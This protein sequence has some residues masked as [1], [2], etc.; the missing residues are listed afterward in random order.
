MVKESSSDEAGE[1]GLIVVQEGEHQRRLERLLVLILNYR[2][3]LD[4][5]T[6]HTLVE[7]FSLFQKYG[8]RIRCTAVIQDRKID[9]KTS[10][11]AISRNGNIPLLLVLPDHLLESHRAICQQ[12]TNVYYCGWQQASGRAPKSLQVQIETAFSEQGIG[13]IFDEDSASLSHKEMQVCVERRLSNIK[14]LP[15]LPAV[16]LRIMAMMEDPRPTAKD[17]EEVLMSDPAIVHKLLQVVNSPIFAGSRYKG[18]WTLQQAIVRLGRRKV[19]ALAQQIKLMNALVRPDESLF[20]LRRF[21]EHST[22]CALICDRLY[23][24]ELVT[25]DEEIDFNAYW[26]GAL[27]HDSGKLVLGFFFWEHFEEIL[28][29]MEST[30]C[31]F[32][33]AEQE[34]CADANHEFLGQLL[35]LKSNAG[36]QL[37]KAVASHHAKGVTPGALGQ[38][39]HVSS[40]LCKDIG[41]GYLE[42]ETVI[43]SAE[44]LNALGLDKNGIRK[45]RQ[46]IGDEIVSSIDELVARCTQPA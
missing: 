45:L 33:E 40:N 35:L 8:S 32:R 26:I 4:L 46:S 22:G 6:T 14:T 34:L 43:Y 36:E 28:K 25:L 9:T 44:V 19:G 1:Y 10:L 17:L 15:T 16:A 39:I 30:E 20:D 42:G 7:A 29:H 2:Y 24:E 11:V 21:W 18:S 41:K 12:M 3:G 37:V 27:L 13:E 38:L 31:T 5:I 23:K